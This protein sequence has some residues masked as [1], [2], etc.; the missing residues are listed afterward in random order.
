M[1]SN[2]PSEMEKPRDRWHRSAAVRTLIAAVIL[3]TLGFIFLRNPDAADARRLTG[4]NLL[5]LWLPGASLIIGT[6]LLL[7][8]T[9]QVGIA[10]ITYRWK[11][12]NHD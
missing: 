8:G 9:A 10:I 4:H 3:V 12:Q 6:L 5:H 1:N 7:I 2:K 11:R